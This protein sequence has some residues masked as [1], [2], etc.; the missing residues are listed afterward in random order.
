M[1]E[2]TCSNMLPTQQM[3]QLGNSAGVWQWEKNEALRWNH[4]SG[5]SQLV[6][7]ATCLTRKCLLGCFKQLQATLSS[8][9][10]LL[11]NKASNSHPSIAHMLRK[12]LKSIKA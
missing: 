7:R 5:L 2:L 12:T 11:R 9:V 6:G 10:S 1:L 8:N 3:A 4:A